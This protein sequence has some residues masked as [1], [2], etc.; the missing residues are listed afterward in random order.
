MIPKAHKTEKKE[1]Y[2]KGREQTISAVC[3]NEG[4]YV[5]WILDFN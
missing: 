4:F 2:C 5:H 3:K 1:K